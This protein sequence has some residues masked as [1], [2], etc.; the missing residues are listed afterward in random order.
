M[1]PEQL[2]RDPPAPQA[3]RRAEAK[4]KGKVTC[5]DLG[6]FGGGDFG[7]M[8]QPFTDSKALGLGV[9]FVEMPIL[10]LQPT[11]LG[12]EMNPCRV[13]A[14]NKGVNLKFIILGKTEKGQKPQSQL[15]GLGD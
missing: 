13:V 1:D 11:W 5:N 6:I 7:D 4:V 12:K 10:T 2:W 15:E 3:R 9:S 8:K 14:W